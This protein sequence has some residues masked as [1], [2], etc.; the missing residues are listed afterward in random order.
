MDVVKIENLQYLQIGVQGE[1]GTL[2]V[3]VDMTSWV[4]ELEDRY[5]N[6]CFHLL[7]KPYGETTALPM[8]TTY[9][10]DTHILTWEITLGA[11]FAVGQGYT[12]I[13]ALNH[14]TTGLLKKS[15][16][17]PTMV[18]SSVSGVEGGT[19]PSPYEDWV[20]QVLETKDDLNNIFEGAT[21]TYQNS[22]SATTVPT[23]EWTAVPAPEKGKYLWSR[24]QFD[25][26]TG[27][28]SYLYVVSYVG[29]DGTATG[30]VVSVNGKQGIIT[31]DAS[32]INVD[33][34]AAV[35]QTIAAALG[36][37]LNSSM[38]VYSPTEPTP[39]TGMI[40]LKPKE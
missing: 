3:Q 20:N 30:A 11:T 14:P 19:V 35:K 18:E 9:D 39:A 36:Q 34:T 21:T 29:M 10:A 23:G 37:K 33:E 16:I 2:N 25:W 8:N 5:P 27:S 17:I 15:R 13:R 28:S 7:F 4:E 40:W 12:E 38:I 1:T 6:L 32:D 31:L 24:I 26:G 22:T